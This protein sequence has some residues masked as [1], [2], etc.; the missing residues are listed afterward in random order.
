MKTTPKEP[1]SANST[2]RPVQRRGVRSVSP[3]RSRIGYI[4][5]RADKV[6]GGAGD[7]TA[8]GRNDAEC[9]RDGGIRRQLL[10]RGHQDAH[11]ARLIRTNI[12][13]R[14]ALGLRGAADDLDRRVGKAED[15][16]SVALRLDCLIE[17]ADYITVAY[18]AVGQAHEERIA[19]VNNADAVVA[20]RRQREGHYP[21]DQHDDRRIKQGARAHEIVDGLLALLPALDVEIGI[22][23]DKT[24]G[25]ADFRHHR[26]AGV[27]AQ[28]AL[29][30]AEI[31]T[32]ADIDAGRA[33]MH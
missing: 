24:R 8:G 20:A 18:R 21:S 4:S 2:P 5:S 13:N 23:C 1:T 11:L 15:L 12:D 27:D 26:I 6:V 32:L 25:T 31:G 19:V 17:D 9:E 10:V 28:A 33:D 7:G 29:N 3:S 14:L 30:A 22:I 16:K